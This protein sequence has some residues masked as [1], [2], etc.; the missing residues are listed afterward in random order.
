MGIGVFGNSLTKTIS[1]FC[2]ENKRATRVP[3]HKIART[4]DI[5]TPFFSKDNMT[6]LPNQI[7]Q[8][9]IRFKVIWIISDYLNRSLQKI[10]QIFF[11]QLIINRF[12][13]F[14][15]QNKGAGGHFLNISPSSE[16]LAALHILSVISDFP[17]LWG[18]DCPFL[19]VWIDNSFRCSQ[20]NRNGLKIIIYPIIN[21]NPSLGL[22][23]KSINKNK[24]LGLAPL[25]NLFS[26]IFVW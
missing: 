10:V 15:Q 12:H 4:I 21:P 9:H 2:R 11:L 13:F 26:I 19:L 23:K 5:L 25:A 22:L 1:G 6:E 20:K 14:L 8:S 16:D 17:L 18:M 24:S 7:V 3:I